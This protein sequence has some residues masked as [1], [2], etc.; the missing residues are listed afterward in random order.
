MSKFPTCAQLCEVPALKGRAKSMGCFG[1]INRTMHV[2]QHT[3]NTC[4]RRLMKQGGDDT[5]WINY[6]I[7]MYDHS[8]KG[9]LNETTCPEPTL[10]TLM[11]VDYVNQEIHS[12]K[13]HREQEGDRKAMADKAKRK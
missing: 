8:S 12:A 13:A 6:I 1:D 5:P 10:K 4:P 11:A 3:L 9:N 2:G 7:E